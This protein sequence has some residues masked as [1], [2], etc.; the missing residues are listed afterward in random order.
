MVGRGEL[1]DQAWAVIAPLLPPNRRSGGQWADIAA[2][3]TGSC[4]G[5]APV[6]PG[7]TCPSAMGP[8]RP[9]T[10]GFAAG[11][12]T[13]PGTGCWR[14]RRPS[15]TRSARLSGPSAWTP[16]STVPIS[17]PPAPATTRQS[18]TGKGG[19]QATRRGIRRGIGTIPRRADQQAAPGC[20]RSG[21]PAQHPGHCWSA[22]REH[23]ARSAA[24]RDPGAAA[25]GRSA[26]QAA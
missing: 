9:A 7:V 17:M 4:G 18:R 20:R 14:T 26:P 11:S 3:S 13:A 25:R 12:R 1:T 15:P 2:R 22:S 10:S 24:G 6:H 5:C 23:P 19:G 8:G 21:P 16:R